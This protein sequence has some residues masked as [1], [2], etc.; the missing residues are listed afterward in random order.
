M[1]SRHDNILHTLQELVSQSKLLKI[2][3]EER[4]MIHS[5]LKN[6]LEWEHDSCSL[7][8]EVDCLFNT[9]NIDNAL[10]NGLI[11]KIEHLVTMIEAILET[12]LSLGFD[13]D[14]IPKL[15]NARSI[16]QWC[17][18]ALSFCSVAPALPVSNSF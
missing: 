17:S 12:G 18:K 8:E 14:E 15:Q 3:L 16:L 6:C 7:L 2:S 1:G 13:F 4:T 11:P 9:N 5:V 10:I